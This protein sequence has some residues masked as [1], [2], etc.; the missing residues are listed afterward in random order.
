[1]LKPKP[2]LI[3]DLVIY[4]LGGGGVGGGGGLCKGVSQIQAGMSN[5]HVSHSVCQ[6]ADISQ[7]FYIFMLSKP[8]RMVS[9]VRRQNLVLLL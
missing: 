3:F 6:L 9:F 4:A 8:S 2:P 1:M 7:L 5:G